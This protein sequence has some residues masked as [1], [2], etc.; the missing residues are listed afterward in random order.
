MVATPTTKSPQLRGVIFCDCSLGV[1][2]LGLGYL[3]VQ[4]WGIGALDMS[5]TQFS[6]EQRGI[7]LWIKMVQF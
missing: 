5:N 6:D 1:W 2:V 3:V 7:K 4:V